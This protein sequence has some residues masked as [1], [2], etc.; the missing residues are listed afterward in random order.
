[1]LQLRTV[2]LI[3]TTCY[4]VATLANFMTCVMKLQW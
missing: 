1:M 2:V 3:F 4:V